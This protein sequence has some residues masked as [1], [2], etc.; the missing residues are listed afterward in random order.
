MKAL[1]QTAARATPERP[2][3]TGTPHPRY[4]MIEMPFLEGITKVVPW[5]FPPLTQVRGVLFFKEV[6]PRLKQLTRTLAAALALA[7]ALTSLSGCSAR[8]LPEGLDE[9]TC[10]QAGQAIVT[11]LLDGDY[12]GVVDAF[13]PDMRNSIGLT[14]QQVEAVMV[15]VIDAGA[16]LNTYQVMAVGGQ[17]KNYDGEYITVGIYCEHEEKDVVYEMSFDTDLEL[18]GLDAKQKR[19]GLFG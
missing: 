16:Y 3:M 5:I 11:M 18:I 14:T 13:D 10:G 19:K 9:E 1:G 6:D 17:S 15:P 8:P 12:Q 4:R 7:A 2:G